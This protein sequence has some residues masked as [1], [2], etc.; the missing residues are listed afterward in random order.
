M[1]F[2]FLIS[3][4]RLACLNFL[5]NLQYLVHLIILLSNDVQ[6]QEIH[7]GT[8]TDMILV[9]LYLEIPWKPYHLIINLLNIYEQIGRFKYL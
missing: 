2:W 3:A 4:K 7:I 8:G 9:L 1:K 6:F 5:C